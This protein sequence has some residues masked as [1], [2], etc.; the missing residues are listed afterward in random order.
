M[1]LDLSNPLDRLY[2]E[3]IPHRISRP[4]GTHLGPTAQWADLE[5]QRAIW[6]L[7]SETATTQKKGAA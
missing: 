3:T 2:L 4:T 1:T 7:A 5:A 6:A